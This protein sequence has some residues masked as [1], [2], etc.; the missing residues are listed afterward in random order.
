MRA[1]G[2]HPHA[3]MKTSTGRGRVDGDEEGRPQP[4]M[5]TNP[6]QG[7][8]ELRFYIKDEREQYRQPDN[9]D[10]QQPS[11][12]RAAHV[13]QCLHL[14][15]IC[16]SNTEQESFSGSVR[17]S[18][19]LELEAI[20][21]HNRCPSN[22]CRESLR[23]STPACS[24]PFAPRCCAPPDPPWL[25]TPAG[26][27]RPLRAHSRT[28]PTR[29]SRPQTCAAIAD[30]T[31]SESLCAVVPRAVNLLAA[32]IKLYSSL[33]ALQQLGYWSQRS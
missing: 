10:A 12:H 28:W 7:R 23:C 18:M 32:A 14:L 6:I 9:I 4:W 27:S 3:D 20:Q 2:A 24:P 25:A 29:A 19:V 21:T 16:S 8:F 13:S 15:C 5:A 33:R 22:S 11:K 26:R 1:S 31:V 30:W 17:E